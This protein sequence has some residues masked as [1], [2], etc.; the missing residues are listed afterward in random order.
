MIKAVIFDMDGVIIDSEPIYLDLAIQ[1]L[2]K[3]LK[4]DYDQEKFDKTICTAVGKSDHKLFEIVS[5]FLSDEYTWEEVHEKSQKE[6]RTFTLNYKTILKPHLI[7]VLKDLKSQNLKL[8][9]ASSSPYDNIMQ[10]VKR[11]VSL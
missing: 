6:W 1:F 3:Y 11:M 10:V 2:K 9:I 4:Q 8:A 7:N 5:E